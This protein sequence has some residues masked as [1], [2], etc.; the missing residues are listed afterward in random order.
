MLKLLKQ[1]VRTFMKIPIGDTPQNYFFNDGKFDDPN[2]E[3]SRLFSSVHFGLIKW[4]HYPGIYAEIFKE[5]RE[6]PNLKILEIGTRY[7]GGIELLKKMF[8]NN[9]IIYGVDIDPRCKSFE[10]LNV[11]IRIGDS[12][13]RNFLEAVSMEMGG[14]DIVID[15]G[16]HHSRHQ[17]KAFEAIFPHLRE[18]G[19][20][21]VEDVE[22]SYFRKQ[23]GWPMF[24]WTFMNYAKRTLENLNMAFRGYNK[25]L[26][27]RGI[28]RNLY[29][30]TFFR[31]V[32]VFR[33]RKVLDPKVV[34]V[35]TQSFP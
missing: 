14:I 15:D 10:S 24:P 2:S 18:N 8:P 26:M 32:I 17:R 11:Q 34:R 16:S 21:L 25:F 7:G 20:Y 27:L 33:K 6:L 28:D 19:I 3:I 13:D 31:S 9:S 29:S 30:V 4:S 35:G 22:H 23:A 1:K 12:S 5:F